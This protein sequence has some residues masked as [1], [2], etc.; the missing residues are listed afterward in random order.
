MWN[1]YGYIEDSRRAS[2]DLGLLR[3]LAGYTRPYIRLLALVSFLILGGTLMDLILPYLTKVAIDRYI[4]VAHYS[5]DE[6]KAGDRAGPALNRAKSKLKPSGRPGLS[7]L[8]DHDLRSL[9]PEDRNA[10]RT[11]GALSSHTWY[12]ADPGKEDVARLIERRPDLFALYPRI[13]AVSASNLEKLTAQDIIQLRAVDLAGLVWV[14]LTALSVLLLGYGFGVGHTILLEYVG[15]RL[16]HD[17]RQRLTAHILKQPMAFHDRTLT[18]RLVA[19]VT[20]DVQNLGEMIK[21]VAVTFFSD[22]FI[23][24]GIMAVMVW[25]DWKLALA[26]FVLLP[27]VVGVSVVFGRLARDVFRE[28]RAKAAEINAAVGEA[29]AG[30]RVVQAFRREEHDAKI[31]ARLNHDN[32]LAG[33]RQIRVFGLFMPVIELIGSAALA[34][35]LWSGGRGVLEETITLGVVVAFIGYIRKLFQPIRDLAEK[36]NILQ[37]AMASLERIFGLMDQDHSLPQAACPV[38]LASGG[39]GIVF[40]RVSFGYP[41]GPKVLD[42]LSFDLEPGWTLAIVGPTGAGKTS[43]ISLLLRFYDP[44]E[45][46]ILVDGVDIRDLSQND[47]RRRLGLVMQDVFMFNGSV[48][49]N[50]ALAREGYSIDAVQAAARAV[51]AD[52]FIR[53]LPQGY[54]QELGEGGRILSVGQRQLISLA[55]IL[56]QKP[57]ILLLDEATAFIDSESELL[58]EK[59]LETLT[60][61]RTS[62]LVAHRLSTIRRADRILVLG[63][64]RAME[65]GT[66]EELL[67]RDGL[68][69]KLYQLQFIGNGAA[70]PPPGGPHP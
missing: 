69:K 37:S 67:A 11:S 29:V 45:G 62:I 1:D 44:Q 13:A 55:R 70:G 10:L 36:F 14:A 60:A 32:F 68:Y 27:V 38:V 49:E 16:A 5:L 24:L 21:S 9:D 51:G 30:L 20:G 6:Q 47:H 63:R 39:G 17:L 26:T 53:V 50:I 3:R 48:A 65:S 15:Q 43:I 31:F 35:V 42:G 46:R 12:L 61:G 25:L 34:L 54:D 7:F 58:I 57:Q 66:H 33:M 56:Y 23:V 22:V 59:A 41:D 52:G 64:G 28:I 8:A 4:V 2:Y 19:R 40:D 18:G